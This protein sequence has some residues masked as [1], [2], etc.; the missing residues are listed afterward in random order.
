VERWEAFVSKF[1]EYNELCLRHVESVAQQLVEE[2]QV[3]DWT[4]QESRGGLKR[5]INAAGLASYIWARQIS[6]SSDWLRIGGKDDTYQVS[7]GNEVIAIGTEQEMNNLLAAVERLVANKRK[8]TELQEIKS[9]KKI[10]QMA[11]SM[12]RELKSFELSNR[13]RGCCEYL[14]I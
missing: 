11:S 5:G 13:L 6:I 14:R 2:S 10:E 7:A 1:V 4:T 3:P 12:T 8:V 9:Q